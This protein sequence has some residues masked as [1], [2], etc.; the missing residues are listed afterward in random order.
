MI[1]HERGVILDEAPRGVVLGP[2]LYATDGLVPRPTLGEFLRAMVAQ[3]WWST[4]AGQAFTRL[5]RARAQEDDGYVYLTEREWRQ[6]P[7]YRQGLAWEPGMT[8]GRARFNAA[9]FD[10]N[11]VRE[12]VIARRRAGLAG[13]ALGFGAAMVGGG[14]RP[15]T[16]SPSPGPPGAP[17]PYCASA[18][19]AGGRLCRRRRP[20]RS[21]LLPRRL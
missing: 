21:P 6:S 7:E 9:I 16:S 12:D 8:R 17:P 15:R 19:S 18:P 10:E 2:A 3:G 13:F 1:P 4:L 20:A 5:R 14:P 11:R